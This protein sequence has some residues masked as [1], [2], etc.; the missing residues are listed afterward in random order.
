MTNLL[1]ESA[2]QLSEKVRLFSEFDPVEYSED[3]SVSDDTLIEYH[4]DCSDTLQTRMDTISGKMASIDKEDTESIPL[5]SETIEDDEFQMLP[6]DPTTYMENGLSFASSITHDLFTD[7]ISFS[8]ESLDVLN[9][10]DDVEVH[11]LGTVTNTEI[12][13][14]PVKNIY[15]YVNIIF[16]YQSVNTYRASTFTYY[17]V[18]EDLY[19]GPK[20]NFEDRGSNYYEPIT[21]GT[22]E[23]AE[24]APPDFI[25]LS[26]AGDIWTLDTTAYSASFTLGNGSTGVISA[27]LPFEIDGIT[28]KMNGTEVLRT[29]GSVAD[30]GGTIAMPQFQWSEFTTT[31]S[32]NILARI[33]ELSSGG[34]TIQ[35]DLYISYISN[36]LSTAYDLVIDALPNSSQFNKESI[37]E[38]VIN[39]INAR[40]VSGKISGKES[41]R[42][43]GKQ[44]LG[45]QTFVESAN[46]ALEDLGIDYPISTIDMTTDMLES[47]DEELNAKGVYGFKVSEGYFDWGIVPN[48]N[49]LDIC[50]RFATA[51]FN[52]ILSF[53]SISEHPS[54]KWMTD[55]FDYIQIDMNE[56][57]TA[58]DEVI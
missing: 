56:T 17:L 26:R 16:Y 8:V 23:T 54:I 29:N 40:K 10:G 37:I 36:Q 1:P 19:R 2:E 39:T 44:A 50:S 49:T 15:V 46:Y 52:E 24:L 32:P 22:S 9:G 38:A 51:V 35:N 47:I 42:A 4:T 28:T 45:E 3:T 7:D 12:N 34:D 57:D 6:L 11:L 41:Y 58:L 20:D 27:T 55:N 31:Q 13:P 25:E 30:L 53:D 33:N 48:C 21:T 43:I 18:T 5:A 14:F